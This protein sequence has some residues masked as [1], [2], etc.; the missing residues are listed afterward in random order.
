MTKLEERLRDGL[1]AEAQAWTDPPAPGATRRRA[2]VNGWGVS[3]IAAAAVFVVIGGVAVAD[4]LG[5]S[6]V[7]GPGYGNTAASDQ[8]PAQETVPSS[9]EDDSS[10]A[11]ATNRTVED[12]TFLVRNYTASSE[13]S[14]V[15]RAALLWD[16][17]STT[18]WQDASLKGVGAWFEIQFNAPVAID[19]IV[20][21]PLADEAGF[22]QNFKVNGY[23]ISISDLGPPV[24]GHMLNDSSPQTIEINSTETMVLRFTVDT[25]YPAVAVGDDPP[26][27]E[28]AIGDVAVFGYLKDPA[29][30]DDAALPAT[31]A[32]TVDVSEAIIEHPVTLADGTDVVISLLVAAGT[33]RP[34]LW[35]ADLSRGPYDESYEAAPSSALVH[36]WFYRSA[37]DVIRGL[38]ETERLSGSVLLTDSRYIVDHDGH[39]YDFQF[40]DS[41]GPDVSQGILDTWVS[42]ITVSQSPDSIVPIVTI[43]DE[44]E[45]GYG[46]THSFAGTY[47]D[48]EPVV[49]A[50]TE[51]C[52]VEPGA[53]VEHS[54]EDRASISSCE[55]DG[56]VE[57]LISG[58]ID[59]IERTRSHEFV[60]ITTNP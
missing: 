5:T 12:I 17:D 20:I 52:E 36:I 58:S 51:V 42:A 23:T 16:G 3:L 22:A 2:P 10:T 41:T 40:D 14:A 43:S 53:P 18:S 46:P 60:R 30:S 13:Y 47:I 25:T 15:Y 19:R 49:V 29:T 24:V 1:A 44:Y 38:E 26:Y 6:D 59:Y 39:A 32:P 7:T 57:L 37:D 28:L 50:I 35:S 54:N 34:V 48:G 4:R 27:T 9:T 56:R 11:A 45:L 21:T 31:T 8:Q 55:L 33:D